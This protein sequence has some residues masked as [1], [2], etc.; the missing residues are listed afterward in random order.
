MFISF[1]QHAEEIGAGAK[2]CLKMLEENDI[3]EI[4]GC[5]N[6]PGIKL[7][8]VIMNKKGLMNWASTGVI[9][10]FEG[11]PSHARTRQKLEE[12]QHFV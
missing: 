11:T 1:F 6:A 2:E 10:R 4:Y 3:A 7:G 5:H 8:K 9:V 12:I